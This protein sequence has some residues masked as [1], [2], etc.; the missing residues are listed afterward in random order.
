MAT[1]FITAFILITM[2]EM[3]DK[4][5][6]LAMAF[7]TRFPMKKVLVGVFFGSLINHGLAVILGT[8]LSYRIP[9]DSIRMIAAVAF[10][11]F[12]IWS[13]KPEGDNGN[14]EMRPRPSFGPVL[15]V[16]AAFFLGEIGD[17]T[18]LTVIALSTRGTAPLYILSGTVLGMVFTSGIGVLVGMKLGK[19]IPEA[20]LKIGSA[21]VFMLFGYLGL[22]EFI[23]RIE[24]GQWI[25][26]ITPVLLTGV[27]SLMGRHLIRE[28]RKSISLYKRTAEQLKLNTRRI[29]ESLENA[30]VES[31]HCA[32]C[33]ETGMSTI[34]ELQKYLK[35]ADQ[36]DAYLLSRKFHGPLCTLHEKERTRLKES[37]KA[38]VTA[39]EECGCHSEKCIGNQT[40]IILEEMIYGKHFPYEGSRKKYFEELAKADGEPSQCVD[41]N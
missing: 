21:G 38:T 37:L 28:S 11:L 41:E 33:E 1:E 9:L 12:G 40:R 2:A 25:L 6:L 10:I 22:V 8:F 27:L 32:H 7:A 31:H 3:G 17:K 26:F 19:K 13:L 5:Q 39:C 20:S 14:E 4:T 35:E 24:A 23:A 34:E 18:Q 16:A 30:K 15:T 29:Y 36:K